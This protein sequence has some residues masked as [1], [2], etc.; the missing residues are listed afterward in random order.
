MALAVTVVGNM[1]WDVGK[2]AC[3]YLWAVAHA[4][5]GADAVIRIDIGRVDRVRGIVEDLHISGVCNDATALAL[6]HALTGLAEPSPD[7]PG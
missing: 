4:R 6:I 7:D 1:S 2:R 3:A 5:L